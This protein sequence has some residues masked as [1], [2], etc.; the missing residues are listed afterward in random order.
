MTAEIPGDLRPHRD[1]VLPA[2]T[3][4]LLID[5]DT[6]DEFSS[7]RALLR[8]TPVL[9]NIRTSTEIASACLL[10]DAEGWFPDLIIV[11]QSWPDQFSAAEVHR[12]L[13][14]FPLARVVCC[15]GCWCDS[16]GRNRSIWPPGS[17]IAAE[18]A[19]LRIERELRLLTGQD[20][21]PALPLTASR[22][23]VFAHDYSAVPRSESP[24]SVRVVSPDRAWR[25][26][27]EQMLAAA[28]HSAVSDSD[29][30]HIDRI[31]WDADPWDDERRESL[32]RLQRD[33]PRVPITAWIGFPRPY[34]VS[35][36]QQCGASTVAF[37]LGP[38][39]GIATEE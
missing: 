16:D 13:A 21:S 11:A 39:N 19:P 28:G 1:P 38:L 26:M 30:R 4:V 6:Q 12:L 35:E 18:F 23:E 33:N 15:Y 5:G 25:A 22:T 32:C 27:L 34:L 9:L 36:L 8:S 10:P 2:A 3:T 14:T 24:A 7:V 20:R 37:K 29:A 31:H 17:R